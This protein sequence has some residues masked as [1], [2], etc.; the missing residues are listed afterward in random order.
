[1]VQFLSSLYLKAVARELPTKQTIYEINLSHDIDDVEQFTKHKSGPIEGVP[2]LVMIEILR[3]CCAVF[4]PQ[5]SALF[6]QFFSII[7]S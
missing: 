5:F 2:L 4:G 1:M 3:Y 7:V 6:C